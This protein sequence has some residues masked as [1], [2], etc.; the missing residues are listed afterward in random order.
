MDIN[1]KDPTALNNYAILLYELRK[2][3]K[4]EEISK[5]CIEVDPNNINCKEYL[6]KMS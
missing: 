6:K 1:G 4:A 2:F 3:D 5:K